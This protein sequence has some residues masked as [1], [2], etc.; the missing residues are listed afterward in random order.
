MRTCP[1]CHRAF[2]DDAEFCPRDGAALASST[3]V[4]TAEPMPGLARRYRITR[5]LGSGGMGTVFLAEQLAVGNRPVAL[6][7][8]QRN[9]LDD[10]EFLNRFQVEASSTGRVR[11]PNVVTIYESGQDD[12]GTPYIAMEY[13]EGETL[14][15]AMQVRGKLSPAEAAEILQQAGRGLNAAH[16]LGIIHRDLKPDNIFL[17][18]DDEGKLLVKVVDF[19]IAKLREISTHTV[20][21]AFL[22]T[23]A[24][25]S[26]EQ[27]AGMR[28]DELDARSDVYSLGIVVYEMLTGRVPFESDTTLGFVRKHLTEPPPHFQTVN[29]DLSALVQ[30]ESVVMK[31]LEKDR[32]QR[33]GSVLDFVREFMQAAKPSA[34][35]ASSSQATPPIHRARAPEGTAG[36]AAEPD[37]PEVAVQTPPTPLAT[38][39][40]TPA[41]APSTEQAS[42]HATPPRT[43]R[44]RFRAPRGPSVNLEKYDKLFSESEPR[45]R[46]YSVRVVFLAVFMVLGAAFWGLRYA[47][48]RQPTMPM[49]SSATAPP[50]VGTNPQEPPQGPPQALAPP[51]V[52]S[53]D[54]WKKFAEEQKEKGLQEAQRIIG[55][56]GGLSSPGPKVIFEPPEAGHWDRPLKPGDRVGAEYID[57]GLQ[58]EASPLP[59]SLIAR[60]AKGS[61]VKVQ[62]DVESNGTI[63]K[64]HRLEGDKS[65][66]DAVIQA[67]KQTWRFSPPV[68]NGVPVRTSAAVV[69]QF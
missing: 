17:A 62:L 12:D 63:H 31:A 69:V 30:I 46:R 27:A 47:S 32:D 51:G 66:A 39:Q 3:D 6:K 65:V 23:P 20:T 43:H 9:L 34:V 67:A 40:S 50:V 36:A 42:A 7:L 41:T 13:L 59:P 10:P 60:A 29:P 44:S 16:K 15:Q 21:G 4:T 53:P 28:S 37:G 52:A 45:G 64:G 54:Q 24:Y 2:P 14:R 56:V 35:A 11:H 49:R 25:M 38:P 61:K 26:F 48:R 68:L 33:Y 1:K 22:G 8:L 57:G 58:L 5:P 19:G 55:E 18:R